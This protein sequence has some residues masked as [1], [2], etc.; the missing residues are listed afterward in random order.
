MAWFAFEA[1]CAASHWPLAAVA[2]SMSTYWMVALPILP[3]ISF[4]AILMALDIVSVWPLFAPVR[5]RL[6]TI[7][8]VPL[9]CAP[10][11]AAALGEATAATADGEA[12]GE[13]AGLATGL[14]AAEAEGEAAAAGEAAGDAAAGFAG[15]V[16]G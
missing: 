9:S 15:A 13:A 11:A 2:S 16:V 1:S 12:A 10:L 14:A 4:S 8:I 5:G 3:L 7:L 6:E